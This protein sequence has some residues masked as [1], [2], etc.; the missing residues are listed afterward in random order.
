[1]GWFGRKAAGAAPQ[2]FLLRMPWG[3]AA[4]GL[5]VAAAAGVA[6]GAAGAA[7]AAEGVMTGDCLLLI[8]MAAALSKW[9]CVLL[10]RCG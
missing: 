8:C 6:T 4:A 3:A 1:M 2:P 10:T 5:G 9:G 7:G